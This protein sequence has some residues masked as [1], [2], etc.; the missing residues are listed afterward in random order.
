M[1][2]RDIQF[3]AE[4]ID[5]TLK[6]KQQVREWIDEAIKEEGFRRIAE[7]NFIFCSD[8]YLLELNQ[9]YLQHDT[10]TDIITFDNSEQEGVIAG[11]I[12]ISIERVRENA[13]KFSVPEEQELR[14]IM[15]HGVL[16][17]CGYHD[18]KAEEKKLMT[19]KEDHFLQKW[20]Q[21]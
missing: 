6:G 12:F 21:S 10:F 2:V 15:I 3:F 1:A 8:R 4:D 20:G 14:R 11:D 17:L 9:Q 13:Q 18:K 5:F 16:H 7:L 19:N